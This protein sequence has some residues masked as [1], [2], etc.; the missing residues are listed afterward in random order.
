SGGKPKDG[1]FQNV[2]VERRQDLTMR[3]TIVPEP[4]LGLDEV[5]IPRNAALDLF[6]PFVVHE[7][8]QMGAIKTPGYGEYGPLL[9]KKPP[10]VWKALERVMA[11]RP[12]LMKRDPALHKY[13]VQAF[14][15]RPVVGNAV[16]IHPLVTS[17]Y[18]A[19]F[20]GDTMSIYV[21]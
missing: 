7:L 9:E 20:D 19:D 17:G 15:A 2:M 21:P 3:S 10:V 4:A 8:K 11:E 16:Q 14:K 1:F 13:S 6:K 5:G 12:V 18:N